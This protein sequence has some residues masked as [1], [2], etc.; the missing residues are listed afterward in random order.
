[1]IPRKKSYGRRIG[2][3]GATTF[4]VACIVRTLGLLVAAV[5]QA[6]HQQVGK[7][8]FRNSMR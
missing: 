2:S 7:A 1:M 8:F 5:G 4:G 3:K 6:S